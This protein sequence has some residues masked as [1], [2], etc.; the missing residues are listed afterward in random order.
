MHSR[1]MHFFSCEA[2]VCRAGFGSS[3]QDWSACGAGSWSAEN[4]RERVHVVRVPVHAQVKNVPAYLTGIIK[5]F[6]GG[7]R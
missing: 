7:G 1:A 5:R 2:E 3:W 6:L 4:P